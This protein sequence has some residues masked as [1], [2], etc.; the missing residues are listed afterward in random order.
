MKATLKLK[1]IGK[2]WLVGVKASCD[3]EDI[4][5]TDLLISQESILH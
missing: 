5:N 2:Y 4:N 3:F 1:Y